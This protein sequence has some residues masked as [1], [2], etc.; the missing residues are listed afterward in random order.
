[1]KTLEEENA[2][3][4]QLFR[5]H[6][7]KVEE[8][9]GTVFG[10][11]SVHATS[12]ARRLSAAS[13]ANYISVPSIQLHEFPS[14]HTCPNA[15]PG[16]KALNPLDADGNPDWSP[17]PTVPAANISLAAVS[18]D[19]STAV[20]QTF[21]APFKLVHDASCASPPTLELQLSTTANTVA[22]SGTLSVGSIDVGARITALEAPPSPP[23]WTSITQSSGG[24]S[25]NDAP[26]SAAY[27]VKDGMVF[28]T[29][30][31]LFG[32]GGYYTGTTP[33]A[34]FTL[35]SGAAPMNTQYCVLSANYDGYCVMQLHY[36]GATALV[37]TSGGAGGTISGL[38]FTACNYLR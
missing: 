16:Y 3:L 24:F 36:S 5:K 31:V 21:V 22:V 35:P 26:N 34:F 1:M 9:Q 30:T 4:R 28:L 19:W 14:G 8:P 38:S 10:D 15:A 20:I 29:G 2:A 6:F 33:Q 7:D 25:N 27:L 17:T 11:G 32:T 23:S 18:S 37:C 12:G 13:N